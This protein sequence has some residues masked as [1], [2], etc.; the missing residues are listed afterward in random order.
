MNMINYSFLRFEPEFSTIFYYFSINEQYIMRLYIFTI[1]P[2]F[3]NLSH[4][5]P[6]SERE[7]CVYVSL[8]FVTK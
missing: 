5:C 4:I 7:S 8:I 6:F 2:K 1:R 3:E